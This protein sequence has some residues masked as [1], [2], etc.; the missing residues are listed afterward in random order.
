MVAIAN[1][2]NRESAT[3]TVLDPKDA[4]RLLAKVAGSAKR[5]MVDTGYAMFIASRSGVTN[6]RAMEIFGKSSSSITL[7]RRLGVALV[8]GVDPE[9]D[10]WRVLS[11]KSKANDA[12]SG[13]AE[14]LDDPNN[15]P[16]ADAIVEKVKANFTPDG[17]ST[18]PKPA[19]GKT[20]DGDEVPP[21]VEAAALIARLDKVIR[22]LDTESWAEVETSLNSLIT[23]QVKRLAT[24]AK[25]D[26]DEK[27]AAAK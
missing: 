5:V 20:G 1:L 12:K 6:K 8:A 7:Y 22:T 14:M 9:S 10:T 13:L 24:A 18:A 26:S 27:V 11:A 16:T 21:Q 17:K 3:D 4:E 2:L 19:V 25:A 23:R 15:V